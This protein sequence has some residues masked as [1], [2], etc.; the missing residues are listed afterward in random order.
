[1]V[2]SVVI[3]EGQSLAS[4]IASMRS[5]Y[6]VVLEEV[7]RSLQNTVNQAN[8]LLDRIAAINTQI[9]TTEGPGGEAGALRDQ[10]DLLIDQ[11]AEIIDV[12]VIEQPGGA[13]DI[14][15]GSTPI[16]LGG[17]SRGIELRTESG[18]G[19]TNVS[20]RVAA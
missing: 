19:T 1:A 18:T 13:V 9:S 20:L 4:R 11:L 5:D 15:V 2:R 3:Q 6:N 14:H 10:R 17:V 7:D 8:D 16:V 12:N